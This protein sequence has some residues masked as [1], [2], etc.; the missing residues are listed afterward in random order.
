MYRKIALLFIVIAGLIFSFGCRAEQDVIIPMHAEDGERVAEAS[1][2]MSYQYSELGG[3]NLRRTSFQRLDCAE[4]FEFVYTFEINTQ[5]LPQYIT[6]FEA[7]VTVENGVVIKTE[8]SEIGKRLEEINLE[9]I[10][11]CGDSICQEVVCLSPGCPC[12]ENETNCP[13]DCGP[14]EP[15]QDEDRGCINLCGDGICQEVVCLGPEC[16]CPEDEITCPEDCPQ[17]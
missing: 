8:F 1:V 12:P 4:C 11:M 14:R 13:E 10:N 16:S 6:G 7:K 5:G 2:M 17:R 9:C 3:H 15:Q